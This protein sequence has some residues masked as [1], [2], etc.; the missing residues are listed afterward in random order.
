MSGNRM[1]WTLE[2]PLGTGTS[3]EKEVE[4][5]E[6]EDLSYDAKS[7]QGLCSAFRSFPSPFEGVLIGELMDAAPPNTIF[8]L[9]R[10]ESSVSTWTAG[11][12]ALMGDGM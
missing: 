11:S 3:G 7:V 10:E 2:Y 1:C 8:S 6:V 4:A 5:P 9:P 12:I